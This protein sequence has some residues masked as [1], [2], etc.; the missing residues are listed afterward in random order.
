VR[1]YVESHGGI[2]IAMT[3][4]GRKPERLNKLLE[5]FGLSVIRGTVGEKYLGRESLEDSQLLNG[6]ASLALGMVWG[7][8]SI[9]IADSNQAE[10]VLQY[11]DAILGAKRPLGKG[12]AY[13]FSCLPAFGNKQLEQVDNRIFLDNLLKSLATPAMKETLEAI[14]K[15]EA[16]AAQA[17]TTDKALAAQ[18]IVGF[19]VTGHSEDLFFTRDRVL[20]VKKGSIAKFL[21]W[22]FMGSMADA[23]Y[24]GYKAG[25]LSELSPDKVL[26][27]NKRNF[28]ISYDEISKIEIRKWAFPFGAWKITIET[29]TDKHAFDWALGAGRDV[30]KHTGFLVPLLSNKLSIND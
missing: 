29:N 24:K 26:T 1:R 28:A 20:V 21:G 23:L 18:K 5:P 10:V 9:R 2:L 25:R 19:I 13:L 11:K 16:L 15:D 6:V 8:E 3:L 27:A 12:T 17:T 4:D 7:Y 22:G 14:A 30:K